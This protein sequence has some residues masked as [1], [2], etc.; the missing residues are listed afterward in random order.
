[1]KPIGAFGDGGAVTTNNDAVAENVRMLR[2]YGSKIKYKHEMLG[3]NSRLDEI[4]AAI[5]GV[6]LKY[7]DDG[8]KERKKNSRKIYSWYQ[9]F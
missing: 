7:V 6:N 5:L 2:N 1:M 8:N 3:I 9:E 4:Q